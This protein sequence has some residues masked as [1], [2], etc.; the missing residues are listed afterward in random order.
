MVL[1][2][3]I[4]HAEEDRFSVASSLAK[5]LADETVKVIYQNYS[6]PPPVTAAE[7]AIERLTSSLSEGLTECSQCIVLVSPKFLAMP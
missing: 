1:Y 4:I 3:F 7:P 5:G 2:I 6:L